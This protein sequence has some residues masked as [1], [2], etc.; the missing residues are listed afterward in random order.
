MLQFLVLNQSRLSA[1]I[2]DPSGSGQRDRYEVNAIAGLPACRV[3]DGGV[4]PIAW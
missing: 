4:N 1:A 3:W 2:R